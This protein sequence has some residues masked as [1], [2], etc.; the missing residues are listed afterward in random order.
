MFLPWYVNVEAHW[1]ILLANVGTST[2]LH[3]H[4][5]PPMSCLNITFAVVSL[6][7][8]LLG[9]EPKPAQLCGGQLQM[10]DIL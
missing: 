2:P 4:K 9:H 10:W 6:I 5:E 1:Y 8:V 3:T 7:Q